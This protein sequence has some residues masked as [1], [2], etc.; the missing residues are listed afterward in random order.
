MR[1]TGATSILDA[2][3]VLDVSQRTKFTKIEIFVFPDHH[4]DLDLVQSFSWS[5]PGRS[6]VERYVPWYLLWYLTTGF[7]DL[8][9]G[10][11]A[12]AQNATR[13][14]LIVRAHWF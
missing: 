1:S 12:H 5:C 9:M 4:L 14:V 8:T 10:S 6:G 3:M 7:V 2:E 13:I 11:R